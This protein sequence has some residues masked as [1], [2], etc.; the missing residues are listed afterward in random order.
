MP[1]KPNQKD[2]DFLRKIGKCASVNS[3][4]WICTMNAN[5]KGKQHMAQIL[6]GVEDGKILSQWPW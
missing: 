2:L 5:H 6:G 1:L 3:D 4:N